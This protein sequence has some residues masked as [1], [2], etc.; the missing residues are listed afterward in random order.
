MWE[1]IPVRHRVQS[2]CSSLGRDC[3]HNSVFSMHRKN[4]IIIFLWFE[5]TSSNYI[6]QQLAIMWLQKYGDKG[7]IIS[8]VA[9]KNLFLNS[10]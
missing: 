9:L 6:S 1:M 3:D 5:G 8:F 4:S 7:Y 2:M 10:R